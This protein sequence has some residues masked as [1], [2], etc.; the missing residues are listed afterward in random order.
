MRND[1]IPASRMPV[2]I[3]GFSDDESPLDLLWPSTHRALLPI[4]G[5]PVI[6]YLIEQLADAGI[7][8]VRITG[9][10]QQY[11]VRNRLRCGREW[12]IKIR[13]SD[14]HKDELLNEC[15]VTDGEGLLLY[16]DRLYD[17]EFRGVLRRATDER[18]ANAA[19]ELRPGLWR[20]VDGQMRRH[21]LQ[22]GN[23]API[24]ENSL[25]TPEDYLRANLRAAG[26]IANVLTVP[27][28]PL[29][30]DAV[31][32]WKSDIRAGARIG[33]QVFIGKHCR[34]GSL[35]RLESNCVL[36][37]GA[38]IASGACLENVVVL[39]N[40][41]VGARMR[42]RDAILGNHGVLS[43]AGQYWPVRN[44]AYLSVTRKNSEAQTGLPDAL[45]E[46]PYLAEKPQVFAQSADKRGI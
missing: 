14:L 5:K 39:P 31:A 13:Y 22:N 15:V 19:S 27:G 7:R 16:G 3:I 17:A 25:T 40:C 37:N 44:P 18:R 34:V 20:F 32:D 21:A 43:L 9:S 38:V 12:G 45:D 26:V 46:L 11:A 4:A 2:A 36:S 1:D 29:H 42:I 41:Y 28:A 10:I 30:R 6:V 8:H 24:Y 35:A 23:G 33:E